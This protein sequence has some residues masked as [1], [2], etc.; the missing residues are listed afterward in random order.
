VRAAWPAYRSVHGVHLASGGSPEGSPVGSSQP[1]EG[2]HF[3]PGHALYIL[4]SSLNVSGILLFCDVSL[5]HAEK[6][7][8]RRR[9][10]VRGKHAQRSNNGRCDR[11]CLI[12]RQQCD[13]QREIHI[14]RGNRLDDHRK[15]GCATR[16][17]CLTHL[18]LDGS[19]LRSA[20]VCQQH[21][22]L[23]R[24][25]AVGGVPLCLRLLYAWQLKRFGLEILQANQSAQALHS[26]RRG[27]PRVVAGLLRAAQCDF[28]VEM[29]RAKILHLARGLRLGS[30]L[31][32][33]IRASAGAILRNHIVHAR[34]Q[35]RSRQPIAKLNPGVATVVL[36]QHVHRVSWARGKER[37]HLRP[38]DLIDE[39]RHLRLTRRR[40]R[41]VGQP[42]QRRL[43]KLEALKHRA[44]V[45]IAQCNKFLRLALCDRSDIAKNLNDGVRQGEVKFF[46]R[47]IRQRG[48]EANAANFDV[49]P[50][51]QGWINRCHGLLNDLCR[52]IW[53]QPDKL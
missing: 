41:F 4:H 43:W 15:T 50:C 20:V 53:I 44:R 7:S 6:P 21:R 40:E 45:A 22:Q 12:S 30:R 3:N 33:S 32:H 16:Q 9:A 28:V 46:Q 27:L 19:L 11:S 52:I 34:R 37:I 47:K 31:A 39:N 49:S 35:P 14:L 26:S 1:A 5:I 38:G 8:H 24:G 23:Q 29:N 18:S 36:A 13:G 42:G 51:N 17:I 25:H 2:R 10:T 48:F